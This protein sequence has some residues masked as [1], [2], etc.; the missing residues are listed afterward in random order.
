MRIY[1]SKT[2]ERVFGEML[3]LHCRLYNAAIQ[4][5]TESWEAFQKK[6]GYKY[7]DKAE[8][9]E[10]R[11]GFKPITYYD[12]QRELT[13]AR[14]ECPELNLLGCNASQETLHRVDRAFSAFYSRCMRGQTPGYPRYKS[15]RRFDSFCF[16]NTGNW[17]ITKR[18]SKKFTLS[19]TNVGDIVAAGSFPAGLENGEPRTCTISRSNGKW[20]ATIS[21]RYHPAFLKRKRVSDFS[22][23]MDFGLVHLLSM[24]SGEVVDNPRHID[25]A[26]KRLTKLQRNLSRKKK[27]SEN[28]KRA[29]RR[30][31]RQHERV[32]NRRNDFLHKLSNRIVRENKFIAVE[33]LK[34]KNMTRSAKGTQEEPGKNVKQKAGLNRALLDASPSR[35]YSMIT[36]KAE[37]AGSVIVKVPA[38]YTSQT[39]SACGNV[40][41]NN[42]K[43]QAEFVC[44]KC[45]HAENADINAAKNILAAGMAATACGGTSV[46][47][48]QEPCAR[49][50]RN[51]QRGSVKPPTDGG[52]A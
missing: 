26:K 47:M 32:A 35:L 10:C 46:P 17:K 37:D 20:F 49:G 8:K 48:K 45:G 40:D 50:F 44:G 34:I 30:V 27:R 28:H 25:R 38:P 9:K 42:R 2:Q 1:P 21:M 4:E 14:Q 51:R 16:N 11:K 41:K 7:L 33:E 52:E 43:T 39:C 19:V 12:Q 13:V 23:G 22:V 18:N 31:A 3:F 24:S 5:R 15:A 29:A 6:T 36:Y